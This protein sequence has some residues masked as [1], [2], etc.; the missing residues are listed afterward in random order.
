MYQKIGNEIRSAR[1][2]LIATL[3]GGVLTMAPGKKSQEAKVREY[4]ANDP[5]TA[6]A[7]TIEETVSV[8]E[9][10]PVD[11][12]PAFEIGGQKVFVGDVPIEH[13]ETRAEEKPQTSAEW[14]AST[15]PENMLP[16][17]DAQFG[18]NTPGFGEFVSK[19]KLNKEQV[20][21]LIKR[22]CRMKGW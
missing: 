19:H 1:G 2:I 16:P 21:A 8:A 14:Q 15:I 11:V 10:A 17:F 5:E 18:V 22:I 13:V 4:L 20:G 6:S 7:S 9:E 12:P 3:N